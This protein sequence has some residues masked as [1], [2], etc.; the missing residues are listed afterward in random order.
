MTMAKRENA[1]RLGLSR[2]GFDADYL[3]GLSTQD[4]IQEPTDWSGQFSSPFSHSQTKTRPV[5]I[6]Y[7]R[8][9]LGAVGKRHIA[10]SEMRISIGITTTEH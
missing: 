7:R 6:R 4:G 10:L 8:M 9:I 2:I 5:F 1:Q 3:S